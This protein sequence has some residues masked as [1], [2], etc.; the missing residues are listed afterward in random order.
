MPTAEQILA[1]LAE[2]ANAWRWLAV[3]WH[4]YFGAIAAL[5]IF[6]VR[7]P[8]RRCGMLLALPFLS[9][10][11]VA[12]ISRN[13]FNGSVYSLIGVIMGWMALRLPATP[14]QGSPPWAL[15][16]GAILFV[17][18][19]VYPHFLATRSWLTYLHSAPTGV[20]PCPTVSIV[21]GS[22]LILNGL[23]SRRL[24]LILGVVGGFYGLTGALRLGVKID[25]L[26]VMGSVCLLVLAHHLEAPKD[27]GKAMAT[28]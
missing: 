19:W 23:G 14:V 17:F 28:A 8:A 3:L 20:I 12:W 5:L 16:P 1:G 21:I 7:P 9:V 11:I 15:V 27:A 22:V 10:G 13:P 26:L 4:V 24:S 25:W 2:V 18:G 6:G